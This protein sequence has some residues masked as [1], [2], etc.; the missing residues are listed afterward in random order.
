MIKSFQ[1]PLFYFLVALFGVGVIS[2]EKEGP[3][4]RMFQIYLDFWNTTGQ[5]PEIRFDEQRTS[6]EIKI[7]F[8]KTFGGFPEG[9]SFTKVIIDNFRIIDANANNYT[10]DQIKAFEF[11]QDANQFREDVEFTMSF[12]QSDDIAVVL[13]LDR[14]ESLGNDFENVQNYASEFVD[15]VFTER[16]NAEMG[17]VDFADDIRSFPLSKD[18][19]A[20]KSYIR[21]IRK[22]KFTTLYEAVDRGIDM[23]FQSRAQSRVLIIF[24]DGADNNSGPTF[25]PEFLLNKMRSDR[26]QYKITSFAIGLE[27]KGD[28]SRTVLQNLSSNGG[29]A[30]FPANA[31]QLRSVF[32]KLS[33]VISN[34]YN[35]TYLRNRQVIPRNAPRKLR[36]DIYTTAQ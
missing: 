35:L 21:G 18:R 6:R 28:I 1:R 25:T 30:E 31:T 5:N 29:I 12:S 26:N 24:T 32:N 11:R 7:D 16:P 13:V 34:V 10:I 8:T 3:S 4:G 19:N 23:L 2:C 33:S 15:R 14:S 9:T 22:G 27:G 17:I 36:F 20:L